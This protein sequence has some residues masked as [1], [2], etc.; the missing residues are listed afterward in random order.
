MSYRPEDS[1]VVRWIDVGINHDE[2][3]KLCGDINV[4]DFKDIEWT[5]ITPVPGGVGILT[6]AQLML[7]VIKAYELQ[8]CDLEM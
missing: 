3:G 4:A 6:T 1:C 2:N 5:M 8:H 7:N